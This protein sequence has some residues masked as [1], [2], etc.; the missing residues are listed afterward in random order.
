MMLYRQQVTFKTRPTNFVIRSGVNRTANIADSPVTPTEEEHRAT[1][2]RQLIE[3]NKA[4]QETLNALQ[5]TLEEHE[6]RRQDSLLE[7][8]QIAVE[9]AVM[10]A[11]HVIHAELDRETLGVEN[12]V[13]NIIDQIGVC[14]PQSFDCILRI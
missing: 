7:L 14:K 9:L 10:A 11:S 13:G 1:R 6:Q 4:L 2:E 8:Q 3:Q 12:M 5:D